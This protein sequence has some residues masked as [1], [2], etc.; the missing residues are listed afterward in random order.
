LI[1]AENERDLK[2]IPS[3][4]TRALEI[5]PVRWIDEVFELALQE[6]PEPIADKDRSDNVDDVSK[7]ER[8]RESLQRH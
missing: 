8:D 7:P 4:I 5:L 1:P 2:D 3:K 6:I